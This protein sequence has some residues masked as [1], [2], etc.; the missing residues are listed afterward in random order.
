MITKKK[1]SVIIIT[2]NRSFYLKRAIDSIISQSFNNWELLVV[3][4][5]NSDSYARENNEDL[6]SNYM[7]YDNIKYIKHEKN[8]GGSVAR[9]TGIKLSDGDFVTF[10][11][12]DDFFLKNRFEELLDVASLIEPPFFIYSSCLIK[13]KENF[14]NIV[15]AEKCNYSK[16]LLESKSFF[17]T[18]SNMFFSKDVF[19]LVGYFDERYERHQ[20][21]EYVLRCVTNGVDISFS[22]K[23]SV[24][25]CNDDRRNVPN[26][27]KYI[28]TKK[29]YFDLNSSELNKYSLKEQNEILF[30]NYKL[31]LFTKRSISEK[32]K[33]YEILNKYNR[34]SLYFKFKVNTRNIIFNFKLS[35]YFIFKIRNFKIKKYLN[36]ALLEDVLY[37][38]ISE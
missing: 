19:Q 25:K 11:D 38:K 10:L 27:S 12:D 29:L 24:V 6:M 33:I 14:T 23:I 1:I 28:E 36:D 8:M 26:L 37:N 18:G 35:N 20:D 16:L 34:V 31:L 21:L 9:N 13:N 32:K 2:C 4:D 17:G 7:I 22:K 30:N 5:N 15:V 3:D